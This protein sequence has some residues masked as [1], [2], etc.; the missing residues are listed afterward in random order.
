MPHVASFESLGVVIK[1][2]KDK[3]KSYSENGLIHI[4]NLHTVTIADA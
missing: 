1:E 4:L 3:I 2:L